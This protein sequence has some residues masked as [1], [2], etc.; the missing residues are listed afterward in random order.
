MDVKRIL[1]Q[2][3]L[4]VFLFLFSTAFFLY[5]HSTGLSW[6]FSVYSLNARY[7]FGD[8]FYFEWYRAPLAPFLMGIFSPFGFLLAEYAFIVFVSALFL[9]SC[10][11][12]S[13]SL[14]IDS[15]LFYALMLNPFLLVNGLSV[16]TELLSISLL[17][18]IVSSVLT[19]R[20]FDAGIAAGLQ[21][22]ARYTN[23]IYL[24]LVLFTKNIRKI[25]L[26]LLAVALLFTP[27]LLYNMLATGSPLTSIA[28]SYALNV[29]Y[30]GYMVM[31]FNI[32]DIL[33]ATNYLFPLFIV[34]LWL[35][36]R[37]PKLKDWVMISIF[38]LALVS[39]LTVPVKEPRYAFSMI[40]PCA[41]FAAFAL[42]K[43]WSRYLSAINISAVL[44]LVLVSLSLSIPIDTLQDRSLYEIEPDDCMLVSNAWVYFNYM[45]YPSEPA[46]RQWEVEGKIENG[47]RLILY[48]GIPEPD[49]MQNESFMHRFPAIEENN[50]YILL[51]D[52][53]KCAP[54]HVVN[55]TY[56]QRLNESIYKKYNYSIETDPCRVLF[57]SFC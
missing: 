43:G 6:D 41:Y 57:P 52:K 15:R 24:P 22:L 10:L 51:G 23:L 34:G 18:L 3:R 42:K 39:Y 4:L 27:W 35:R 53:E 7:M 44:I 11:R 49:Y 20:G 38:I 19:R 9:Y 47:Y 17:Q 54:K 56:L 26:A 2:N 29:L 46:P 5:Q 28:N 33:I 32:L 25:L 16:G 21:S 40:L 13:E 36:R 8:G 55:R 50:E 48:K 12:L 45:G 14:R 30:R 1:L 37:R 31:P